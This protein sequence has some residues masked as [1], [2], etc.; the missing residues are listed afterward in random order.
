MVNAKTHNGQRVEKNLVLHVQ[1]NKRNILSLK[2]SGSTAKEERKEYKCYRMQISAERA[3]FLDTTW[4]LPQRTHGSCGYLSTICTRLGPAT[5]LLWIKQW[6]RMST[7]P[8][9]TTGY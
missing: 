1:S 5:F 9:G 3:C 4:P 8:W 6:P 2:G 7:P